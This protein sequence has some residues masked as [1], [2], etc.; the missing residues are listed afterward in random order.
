[1][2]V[3]LDS[4]VI[5][6]LS[7][8]GILAYVALKLNKGKWAT[9]KELAERL[10]VPQIVM[11]EG[12]RNLACVLESMP[13]VDKKKPIQVT[14]P[15]AG[16]YALV[17]V[18]AD[19]PLWQVPQRLYDKLVQAFPGISVMEELAKASVWLEANRTR[20]KT[21]GG[22]PKFLNSWMARAQNRGYVM[23]SA[24]MPNSAAKL[25]ATEFKL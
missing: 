25:T 11:E 21:A 9:P 24:P 15:E 19:E 6:K 14:L 18:G 4:E 23:P 17:L 2:K 8:R 1:M 7:P 3:T 22:M 16:V 10:H 20:R 12:N 5:D 13:V